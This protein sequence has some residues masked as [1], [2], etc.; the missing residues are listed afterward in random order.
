[1]KAENAPKALNAK[2]H[3]EFKDWKRALCD[4]IT[5]ESSLEINRDGSYAF[6]LPPRLVKLVWEVMIRERM[7]VEKV[8]AKEAV[9]RTKDELDVTVKE[10]ALVRGRHAAGAEKRK[11]EEAEAQAEIERIRAEVIKG[12]N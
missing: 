4:M 5:R 10:H 12:I 11:Q 6:L 1:M 9:A 2:A 3:K 7:R 8:S